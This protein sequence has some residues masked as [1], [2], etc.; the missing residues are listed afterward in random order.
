MLVHFVRIQVFKEISLLSLV[1]RNIEG[2]SGHIVL[3]LTIKVFDHGQCVVIG[4]LLHGICISHLATSETALVL[5]LT[6]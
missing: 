4:A 2:V 3:M 1:I 5:D 6:R